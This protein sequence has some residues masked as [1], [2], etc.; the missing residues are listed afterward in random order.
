MRNRC[1]VFNQVNFQTC[2][3]QRTNRSFATCT[4]SFNHNLNCSHAM[5]HRSFC[6]R[7]GSHLRSK[8]SAFTR[9]FEPEVTGACPGDC[10]PVRVGNGYDSV[11][12]RRAD[13]SHSGVDIFPITTFCTNDFFRFSHL[14]VTPLYYFFLLAT[15]RRGPL[16]VRAFVLVR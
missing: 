3:L 15:V 1:N 4:R 12:E 16:R 8:R 2:S 7:F 14:K 11:V 5:L 13:M 10:I 9:A 6:R